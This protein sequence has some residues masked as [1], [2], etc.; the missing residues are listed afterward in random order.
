MRRRPVIHNSH[1]RSRVSAGRD[2]RKFSR[3]AMN[4]SSANLRAFPSRDGY[5]I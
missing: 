4:T 5:R 1:K 3:T 2:R